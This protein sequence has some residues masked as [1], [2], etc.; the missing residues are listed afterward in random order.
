MLEGLGWK[1]PVIS[2]PA[3]LW[4]VLWSNTEQLQEVNSLMQ[5]HNGSSAGWQLSPPTWNDIY[6]SEVVDGCPAYCWA[7]GP[8]CSARS[9][10]QT[11]GRLLQSPA[12]S[13]FWCQVS[14]K[15][16]LLHHVDRRCRTCPRCP[17]RRPFRGSMAVSFT[18]TAWVIR[19]K[20]AACA[21]SSINDVIECSLELPCNNLRCV[22][23]DIC[24]WIIMFSL[25]HYIYHQLSSKGIAFIKKHTWLSHLVRRFKEEPRINSEESVTKTQWP[26][27]P[28]LYINERQSSQITEHINRQSTYVPLPS[29][30]QLWYT[31][32]TFF[33]KFQ[34]AHLTRSTR[35]C[36]ASN[37]GT[38]Y[39]NLLLLCKHQQIR[40]LQK[41]NSR[42]LSS[43]W[44]LNVWRIVG[45]FLV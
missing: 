14:P 36:Q 19:K 25:W 13:L 30:I 41:G 20:I 45:Y 42:F 4:G 38:A 29:E 15:R 2:S 1:W 28:R 37:V 23:M 7:T 33:P 26:C 11:R 18:P 5:L 21:E 35:W 44:V 39:V 6:E 12:W 8:P 32:S 10:R 17:M 40:F 24:I 22:K 16:K 31:L 3:H 27:R 43:Y 9:G 34:S